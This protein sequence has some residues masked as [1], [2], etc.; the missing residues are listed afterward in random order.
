[1]AALCRQSTELLLFKD[2]DGDGKADTNASCFPA[3]APKTRTTFCTRLRWGI[4]GQ[5]YMNQ[6][7][8][9]HSHIE[10]PHGVV[11]LNSGGICNSV[12]PRWNWTFT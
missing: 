9:I 7:I 12:P 8:Y 4:D 6:S 3:S 1:M 10:T 5:L 11:R 2:T